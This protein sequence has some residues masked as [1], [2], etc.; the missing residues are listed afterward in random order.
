MRGNNASSVPSQEI[1]ATGGSKRSRIW[2]SCSMLQLS[3]ATP[4]R[5]VRTPSLAME[6]MSLPQ[7]GNIS[8]RGDKV[9]FMSPRDTAAGQDPEWSSRPSLA[10]GQEARRECRGLQGETLVQIPDGRRSC[11][12]NGRSGRK[13]GVKL[14]PTINSIQEKA[15]GRAKI[16]ILICGWRGGRDRDIHD[17][18]RRERTSCHIAASPMER[19]TAR[20]TW[21]LRPIA[22]DG[23]SHR[24]C[25]NQRSCPDR[26]GSSQ[27]SATK[28]DRSEHQ[29]GARAPLSS[30]ED[31][32]TGRSFGLRS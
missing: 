13:D 30:E 14:G 12:R 1:T 16:C 2:E 24:A 3:G 11:M 9:D 15:G 21:R 25:A 18:S 29:K 26:G 8:V 28:D 10:S 5:N 6:R 31:K 23:N 4:K 20:S 7:A 22:H 19:H 32:A 17:S 27:P